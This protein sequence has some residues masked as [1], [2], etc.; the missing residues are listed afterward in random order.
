M[1]RPFTY[2][3]RFGYYA[4]Q[5]VAP[6]HRYALMRYSGKDTLGDLIHDALTRSR[7][8]KVFYKDRARPDR[9]RMK[10]SHHHA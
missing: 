7:I 5:D 4:E 10:R 3:R 8:G 9:K 2:D 1:T 6:D